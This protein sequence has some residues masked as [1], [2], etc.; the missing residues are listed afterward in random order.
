MQIQGEAP[1]SDKGLLKRRGEKIIGCIVER[2]DGGDDEMLR[3]RDLHGITTLSYD[4]L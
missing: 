4:K 2:W 1:V 3:E